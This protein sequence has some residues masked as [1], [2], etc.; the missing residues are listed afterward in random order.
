LGSSR[1]LPPRLRPRGAE[2]RSLAALVAILLATDVLARYSPVAGTTADR[3]LAAAADSA[4]IASRYPGDAGIE[5]D[6]AVVFVEKFD[7]TSTAAVFNRWTD[8]LNGGSMSLTTDVPLGSS[9]SRSLTIPWTGGGVNTGGHLYKQLTPGIDDTLYIRYYVKYPA[10]GRYAHDGIWTGGYNPALAWPN[11]QAGTKPAGNDRFS[12]AAE[13]QHSTGKF[14]HY[15]YWMNMRL[16]GD[17]N[18]WGNVLLNNPAATA[19]RGQWICVEQMVKLNNPVSTSNGEHAIWLNGVEMSHLGPGFPNGSWSGGNFIQSPTGPAFEGFRWRSDANLKLNYLWLQTFAP[20]EAAGS[21]GSMKFDH[22]VAARSYVGCLSTAPVSPP[23]APTN[24]RIVNGAAPPPPPPP[25]PPPTGWANEPTGM[26]QRLDWGM[27]QAPPTSG[28]VAI[29]GSPGVKIV[30]NAVPGDPMG[31][32]QLAADATAPRSPS[33]VYDFVYPQGMIEGDAP[34]TMYYAGLNARA[35]YVGFWWKPSSP[36]DTGPNGNKIAFIFNGGGGAGGQQFLILMPDGRLHVLPEYPGD[37]RWR[38][39]NVNATT[40]TLG[41]WHKIEW[42]SDLNSGT[43]K[44]W[45]D[46]VLQ[47]SYT[48]VTNS[49]NF[50]MFQFSPTWGGNSGARKKQTDHYWFDHLRIS[51]R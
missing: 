30:A 28:D 36:F 18:Y 48:N 49:F 34:A 17:G 12:A 19:P 45:M 47:G 6:P 23:A 43:L 42:Y 8:I 3:G 20:D 24:L 14:D 40:V 26:T 29:P 15:D 13:V 16:S 33:S 7:E 37:Y 46:G 10:A 32:A 5:S 51:T 1:F 31:W 2:P 9:G 41:A 22:V 21:N 4:G 25:P 35:V 44:W 38:T 11:P 27:D 50:D 39:P